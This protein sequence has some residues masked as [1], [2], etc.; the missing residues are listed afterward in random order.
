MS[1][2]LNTISPGIIFS[3]CNFII[4]FWN[5]LSPFDKVFINLSFS[6]IIT[7]FM[8]SLFFVNSGYISLR[9]S[10]YMSISV[11]NS[12]KSICNLLICLIILL[13]SLL[14]TYPLSKLLGLPPSE[15][16]IILERKCSAIILL[17][18]ILSIFCNSFNF[19][20]TGANIS[21]SNGVSLPCNN[22]V[23]LSN[24]SPVSTFFCFNLV[25]LP[26]ASLKYSIKTLFQISTY[27][28]Q[29]HE[30]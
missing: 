25:Y 30:G 1:Y 2:S 16:I 8:F 27:F 13:I 7:F 19:S 23:I 28:P 10:T 21:V 6:S 15:I 17:L 26:F 11:D 29:S 18:S 12:D 14:K 20:I 3:S 9:L 5:S 22:I 24:P 4:A